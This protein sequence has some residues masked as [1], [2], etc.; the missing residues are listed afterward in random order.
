MSD[1]LRPSAPDAAADPR[2]WPQHGRPTEPPPPPGGEDGAGGPGEPGPEPTAG[3]SPLADHRVRL[4]LLIASV[5]ALGVIAGWPV[6]LMV[7]AIVVSV[8]LHEM[9]HYLVA[10]WAGMKVTEFFIGFGP[11]IWSFQRGETEYG[12]K[13]IPA[14]AYVRIIGMHALEEVDPAD[15]ERTYRNKPFLK[16]LPVVLAGPAMN[17]L[18]GLVL[19]VVIFAGFGAPQPDQWQVS[20]VLEGSAAA[21]AGVQEGDRI[22][23]FDGRPAGDFDEFRDLVQPSAGSEVALVVERDGELVP[24]TVDLGWELTAAGAAAVGQLESGDRVTRVGDTEVA[25]YGELRDAL[26]AAEGPVRVEFDR[27]GFLYAA[28]VEGPVTLPEDGDRGLL[29]VGPETPR[30]RE[31]VVAATGD[32]VSAFGEVTVASVQGLGRFF[33]PDGLSRYAELFTPEDPP[34]SPASTTEI[35]P[36]DP[37]APAPES[38]SSTSAGDE[39][40]VLSILGVIRLGSQAA[41]GGGAGTFLFLL[42]TVNIFLGLINLLP[43]LP[44]DGGHAAVAVYEGIRSRIAGRPYRADMAKLMPVTYVV[45]FLFIGLGLSSLYLD[46]VNPAENPFGP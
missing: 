26:A 19:L 37:D 32:A 11:R 6:L 9:G 41:G 29:G 8:F 12:L 1:T 15:E 4:G 13:A 44:F 30:V 40:R 16:R 5:V 42:I 46:I 21:A 24:L 36:L 20:R 28:E 7:L 23:E 3:P 45:V 27:D 22:V 18:I 14:G 17:L 39:D 25:D 34:A 33:S 43:L 35:T 10:K 31:N 38:V 2:P